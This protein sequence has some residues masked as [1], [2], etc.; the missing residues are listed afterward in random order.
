MRG[1]R[2]R[3]HDMV[4]KH[5][6]AAHV[7]LASAHYSLVKRYLSKWWQKPLTVWHMLRAVRH[8][9]HAY[10]LARDFNHLSIESID[11]VTTIWRRAPV[12]L[13]GDINKAQEGVRDGL[14]PY[15]PGSDAIKPH[16]RA[17]LYITLAEIQWQ[18][19]NELEA[20][21]NYDQASNLISAIE[22]E[23]CPDR[24]QQMV[25]VLSAIGFFKLDHGRESWERW[26]GGGN[27]RYALQLASRVSK[28]QEQKILAECRK[29]NLQLT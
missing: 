10:D 26:S 28:D 24:E 19:G 13:G 23:N 8:A 2:G 12:W 22:T 11:V 6:A 27:L 29:R 9:N 21:G 15:H 18:M 7:A 16:T 3:F 25:R 1:A 17:L 20:R 5:P 4:G 14:S